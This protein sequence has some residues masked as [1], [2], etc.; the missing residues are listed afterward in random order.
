MDSLKDAV[1]GMDVPKVY[2]EWSSSGGD[3]STLGPGSAF[4]EVLRV[5]KGYNIAGSL[6][7]EYPK[8]DWEWVVTNNPEVIIFLA[9]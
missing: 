3:L 4:D 2:L 5:T 1:D 6:K 8:V 9:L 7:E